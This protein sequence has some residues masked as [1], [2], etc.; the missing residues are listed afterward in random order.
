[1]PRRL[2]TLRTARSAAA[3][4]MT[5]AD[6][7]QQNAAM[8]E[9]VELETP[10]LNHDVLL[11]GPGRDRKPPEPPTRRDRSWPAAVL[12]QAG[13]AGNGDVEP[14][15][16]DERGNGH[17]HERNGNRTT[18]RMAD[19]AVSVIARRSGVHATVPA[20]R[21]YPSGMREAGLRYRSSAL[22]RRFAKFRLRSYRL[23]FMAGEGRVASRRRTDMRRTGLASAGDRHSAA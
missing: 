17:E 13:L 1:M 3:A 5:D 4:L 7:L 2:L 16:R 21:S 8:V 19:D 11:A 14:V 18:I 15:D 12:N 20:G 23:T 6:D 10:D 22:S 9:D